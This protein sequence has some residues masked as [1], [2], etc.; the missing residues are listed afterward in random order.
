MFGYVTPLKPEMKIKDFEKFKSYYCGLCH[1]IKNTFGNTPR[2][3]LNYDMTFLGLLFDSLIDSKTEYEEFRCSIHPT[4]KRIRVINN[5]SLNYASFLN[6]ALFYYKLIDDVNDDKNLKANILSHILKVSKNKFDQDYPIINNKIISELKNLSM[7]EKK[8]NLSID[9]IAD[10]FANLTAYIIQNYPFSLHN[11]SIEL[12]DTLY[13]FGYNLGKWIY[14]IDAADDLKNDLEKNK[15]N[16]LYSSM[17]EKETDVYDFFKKNKERIMF[18][19]MTCSSNCYNAYK[20]LP[21]TKNQDILENILSLG[22]MD[23]NNMIFNKYTSN[24]ENND[25]LDENTFIKKEKQ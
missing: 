7:K 2:L 9:E 18:S 16:A 13:T 4:K 25:S 8:Q 19:L 6:I 15:F 14:I 20:K 24:V 12:R 5:N 23:K 1:S 10:P 22:I 11:D 21:V 17:N 3:S